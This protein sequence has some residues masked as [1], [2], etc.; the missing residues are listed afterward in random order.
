MHIKI[1]DNKRNRKI[2]DELITGSIFD[3]ILSITS[4]YFKNFSFIVF[5]LYWSQESPCFNSAKS[6][7]FYLNIL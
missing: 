1:L 5:S 7:Q 4:T 3:F 2:C 6:D